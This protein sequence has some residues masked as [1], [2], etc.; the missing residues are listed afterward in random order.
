MT[1]SIYHLS[2]PNGKGYI[3]ITI[4]PID[5]RLR[6]HVGASRRGSQLPVHR[7]IRKHGMP[8]VT[9]LDTNVPKDQLL[10]LER[11]A[12]AS[13][14][15]FGKQ[16]YNA[17]PG[18]ENPSAWLAFATEE[19]KA[20]W[21]IEQQ[22]KLADYYARPGAR[23]AS[24]NRLSRLNADPEFQKKRRAGI[25]KA[26]SDPTWLEAQRARNKAR[27]IVP[28]S[29]IPELLADAKAL[30]YKAACKKWGIS[31]STLGNMKRR[32]EQEQTQ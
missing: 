18:G 16:G 17:S 13:F 29:L 2:F 12:I 25:K 15:T 4:R 7:A 31:K 10:E 21:V 22:R 9:V 11:W 24:L 1:G 19:R 6:E 26:T 27:Q 5:E 28:D 32:A 14:E 23:E 30:G 20:A 3:G 8:V